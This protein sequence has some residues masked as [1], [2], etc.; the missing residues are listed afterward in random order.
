M[1][2]RA[3]VGERLTNHDL[4]TLVLSR[5]RVKSL[6][7]CKAVSKSWLSL[8]SSPT[9]IKSHLLGAKQDAESLIGKIS[10]FPEDDD[11]QQVDDSFS[12]IRYMYSE[13]VPEC[14][15]YVAHLIFPYSK[16]DYNFYPD[17]RLV[18]SDCGIV[19]VSVD[20]SRN[21]PEKP[22][23][24]VYLWNPAT[25][26]SKLIPPHTIDIDNDYKTSKKYVALGVGFDLVD[27]DFKVVRLVYLIPVEVRHFNEHSHMV[28]YSATKSEILSAV[29]KYASAEVY[30]ANKNIWQNI[31]AKLT[32]VPARSSFDICLHGFLL[33]KG[34][35]GMVAFDLN[36][37]VFIC[38]IKLPLSSNVSGTS[39]CIVDF[40]DIIAA[41]IFRGADHEIKLWTLDNEACLC[42]G[43]CGVEASW[44]MMLSIDLSQRFDFVRGLFNS[45]EFMLRITNEEVAGDFFSY[46]SDKKI[47]RFMLIYPFF[48]F[49]DVFKYQESLLTIPGS[50]QIDWPA[51]EDDNKGRN[52]D[53]EDDYEGSDADSEDDNEESNADSEDDNEES[54]A[55]ESTTDSEYSD[56]EDDNEEGND[57]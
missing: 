45:V 35:N 26:H 47:G 42:S 2:K 51:D 22:P 5:L 56:S 34:Y 36:K 23:H 15:E 33:A 11:F 30:S 31:N 53:S 14:V 28:I 24:D 54:N 39:T 52:A 55:E 7:R 13:Y 16:G 18:G 40:K 46:N 6:L 38:D 37:E 8:I 32:D 25:K 41:V 50:K 21:L 4:L 17:S 9:F 49:Y 10:R 3:D 12:L 44:T 19:C 27:F 43:D 1:E 57:D 29:E 48:D 20:V